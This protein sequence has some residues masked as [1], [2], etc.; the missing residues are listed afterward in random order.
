MQEEIGFNGALG[1]HWERESI[2]WRL[3]WNRDHRA[4]GTSP[5]Y[6]GTRILTL[7]AS[8]DNPLTIEIAYFRGDEAFARGVG[9]V[10]IVGGSV[11][12]GPRCAAA[13]P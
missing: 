6:C 4:I 2:G 8:S 7:C 12:F 3:M 10:G 11:E 13:Q 5:G 1:N 9:G